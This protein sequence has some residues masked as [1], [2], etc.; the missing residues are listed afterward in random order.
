NG[1]LGGDSFTYKVSDGTLQS[2]TTTVSIDVQPHVAIINNNFAGPAS[3]ALG[4]E[5]NPFTSIAAFNTANTAANHFDIVYL[6]KGTGTYTEADGIHL[7]NG[8]IL[9]GQGDDLSY[10]TSAGAPGGAHVVTLLDKDN[11]AGSIPT[12]T[13]TGAGNSAVYL[14]QNNTVSG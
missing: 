8:Q 4:S 13:V 9:L 10:T 2:A 7:T 5:T 12:I 1:Y 6:E 14:A 11:S 3:G